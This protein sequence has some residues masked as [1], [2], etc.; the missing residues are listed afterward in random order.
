MFLN[1]EIIVRRSQAHLKYFL[2]VRRAEKLQM[3]DVQWIELE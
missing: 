3:R 1:L 2:I